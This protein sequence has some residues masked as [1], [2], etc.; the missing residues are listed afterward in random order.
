[1][2]DQEIPGKQYRDLRDPAAFLFRLVG[3]IPRQYLSQEGIPLIV[4]SPD[5]GIFPSQEVQTVLAFLRILDNP[6][7]DIP[8][9]A[10]MR[11]FIGQFFQLKNWPGSGSEKPRPAFL[12]MVCG[13]WQGRRLRCPAQRNRRGDPDPRRKKLAEENRPFPGTA[14]QVP[15][16]GS[17]YAC[18][19]FDPADL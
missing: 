14:A 12:R 7:Q 16:T 10:V 15:S 13:G 6:R 5:R 9:T 2:E 1:M 18:P 19:C 17:L 4:S 11:S 3:N 8:L